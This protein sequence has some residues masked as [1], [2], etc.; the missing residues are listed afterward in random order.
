MGGI[1][2]YVVPQKSIQLLVTMHEANHR[3]NSNPIL[4]QS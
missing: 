1:N 3:A 4:W 2:N